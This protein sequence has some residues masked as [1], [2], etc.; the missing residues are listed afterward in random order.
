[1]AITW[2]TLQAPDFSPVVLLQRESR[3]AINSGIYT[4]N[5]VAQQHLD[6]AQQTWDKQKQA[7]TEAIINQIRGMDNSQLTQS[8]IAG[9]LAPYGAQIDAAQVRNAFNNQ[10]EFIAG[11][12]QTAQNIKDSTDHTQYGAV[13]DTFLQALAQGDMTK[14]QEL[15]KQLQG[16]VYGVDA[17][18]AYTTRANTLFDQNI[19]NRRL[20]ME[21]QANA[22]AAQRFTLDKADHDLRV[23]QINDAR[24]WADKGQQIYADA[25]KSGKDPEAILQAAEL[26]VPAQYLPYFKQGAQG[27]AS[28]TQLTGQE[29]ADLFTVV[30]ETG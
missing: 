24:S 19:S 16:T 9:L 15:V 27:I 6:A 26:N 20:A 22:L 18:N 17:A 13:N 25:L 3:N 11:N 10:D 5:N 14:A 4:I 8:D 28:A 30:S 29:K 12:L 23:Q 2:R 1:M 7:N 21:G